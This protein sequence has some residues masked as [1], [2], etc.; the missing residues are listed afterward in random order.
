MKTISQDDFI[1]LK[2][3]EKGTKLDVIR[4]KRNAFRLV[5]SLD[6]KIS[7]SDKVF[8]VDKETATR[9]EKYF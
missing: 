9:L 2:I 4:L 5:N 6:T 7:L 8:L 1:E 3:I